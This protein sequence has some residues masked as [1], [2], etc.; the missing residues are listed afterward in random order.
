MLLLLM[1]VGSSIM[2]GRSVGRVESDMCRTGGDGYRDS[3]DGGA[4]DED[5]MMSG[6]DSSGFSSVL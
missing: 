3:Y 2:I 6:G 1:L 5:A 4:R